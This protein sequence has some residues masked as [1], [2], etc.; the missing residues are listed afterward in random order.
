MELQEQLNKIFRNVFGDDEIS[1]SPEMTANDVAGWDSFSH[2]T[3]IAAIES[4]F[5]IIFT[6]K[7]AMSFGCV[8]DLMKCVGSK[9]N[10]S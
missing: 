9:I 1:I 10:V 5:K 7:E 3:L 2:M 4:Q 8:G 6:R